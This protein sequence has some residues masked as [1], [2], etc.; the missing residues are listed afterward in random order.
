MS[1]TATDLFQ[2]GMRGVLVGLALFGLV[3][4]I[5]AVWENPFFVRMTP[6]GPW[7]LAA[8]TLMA[9]L[10]GVTAALWVP[11][12]RLG[13]TGG[14]GLAS[15]LGIACPTCNKVLMLVFGGQ[16]LLTWFDPL[17]PYLAALGVALMG[18]AAY[19]SWRSFLIRRSDPLIEAGTLMPTRNGNT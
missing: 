13:G 15:F 4:T 12:C 9:L 7:E 16:A 8:T 3:G 6:I 1:F 17:R 2:R 18:Y 10:G 19:R 5:A 14:G 11:H